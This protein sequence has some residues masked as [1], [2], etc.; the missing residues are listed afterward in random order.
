MRLRRL[1]LAAAAALVGSAMVSGCTN[2]A[3]PPP[4]PGSTASDATESTAQ[5]GT[6]QSATVLSYTPTVT[7]QGSVTGTMSLNPGKT[8]TLHVGEIVAGPSSTMVTY[9]VTG[10]GGLLVKVDPTTWDTTMPTLIDPIGKKEYTVTLF[11][12]PRGGTAG[13][14]PYVFT[15]ATNPQPFTVA[16]PALPD[17][18]TSVEVTLDGFNPDVSAVVTRT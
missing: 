16:Y 2:D 18:V 13:I 15:A 5:M 8:V 9:W 14:F 12:H 4:Q 11:A 17:S 3:A 1:A 6:D 10:D 7:E